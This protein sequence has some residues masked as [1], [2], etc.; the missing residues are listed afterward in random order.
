MK[1][2]DGTMAVLRELL[3]ATRE[4]RLHWEKSREG[5]S[6]WY[7]ATLGGRNISFR[8]LYF[9]PTNQI[10]ADRYML[11]LHMPGLNHCFA[12]GTEG[13]FLL[14]E[15][16]SVAFFREEENADDALEFLRQWLPKELN[17][18]GTTGPE[19]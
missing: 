11:D 4:G 3:R 12:C 14:L 19:S 16:Y 1:A 6:E 18:G 10:G 8:F 15:T 5:D 2:F 13:Y 7:T 9:E 17:G